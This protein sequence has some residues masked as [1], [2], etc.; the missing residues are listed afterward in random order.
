VLADEEGYFRA[1]LAGA[2]SVGW[3][4][5]ALELI[6]CPLPGWAPMQTVADVLVPRGDARFAVISD[7][8][9]T[10]LQTHVTHALRMLWVTLSGNAF[11]RLPFTGTTE[12]YRA[13]AAGPSGP[14]HNPF[15]YVSKSPWNLY[16]FLIEFL[17]YQG[18]P[19]GP[20]FLR[21]VGLHHEAPLDFK[22]TVIEQ[23]FA[24]YPGLPFVLVGDSGERDPDIYLEIAARHPGRVPVIYIR[25]IGGSARRR[26]QLLALA[27]EARRHEVEL[28]LLADAHEALE[29][30]RRIGLCW[31]GHA[32]RGH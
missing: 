32:Q 27:A 18:L 20:M 8:D 4:Q 29:H 5:A 7:I 2:A 11:T 15:F 21:D 3:S 13:L 10:V 30:A 1:T 6:D 17:E 16:E 22:T 26:R 28:L 12:L 14:D 31:S 9:D 23:L 24:A 25:D 19:R